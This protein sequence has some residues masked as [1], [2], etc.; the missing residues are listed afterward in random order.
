MMPDDKRLGQGVTTARDLAQRH[1][2]DHDV[3]EA[4]AGRDRELLIF[5]IGHGRVPVI[6]SGCSWASAGGESS[7]PRERASCRGRGMSEILEA[8]TGRKLR[9]EGSMQ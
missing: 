2:A 1:L 6:V 7:E 8:L 5:I 4:G 9:P 3:A